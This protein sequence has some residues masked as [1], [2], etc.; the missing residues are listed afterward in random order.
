[1]RPSI[2]SAELHS[3]M[4]LLVTY[5]ALSSPFLRDQT[6]KGREHEGLHFALITCMHHCLTSTVS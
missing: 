5:T 1:M 2:E 3:E 4:A 6:S